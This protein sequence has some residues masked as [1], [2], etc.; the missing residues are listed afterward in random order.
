MSRLSQI[1]QEIIA[2]KTNSWAH[3]KGYEPLYTASE[4]A[5]LVIIGQA[6][7]REAQESMIPWNDKS[8]IILRDW[9]GV[10]D[11]QFYDDSIVSL[12]PM[13][14]YFP[15]KGKTGD[16]KPR[17]DF[18]PMWHEK[19]LNEM[20][21]VGLI[22]LV[23]NYSQKY[24]LKKEYKSNLTETVKC[25]EQYLPKYFPIVHSSPLN[26]RW[27]KRNPWF[28]ESVVPKLRIAISELL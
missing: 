20:P 24:Y 13:D 4:T 19:I 1:R 10:S 28:V 14:F 6:P 21:E 17:K 9:L 15:G 2:D 27:Q 22:I 16:L 23:G 8:G 18:A 25:Y 5:K 11:E 3:K 7:G 12:L 26:F